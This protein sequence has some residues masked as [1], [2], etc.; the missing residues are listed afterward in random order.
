MC[1]CVQAIVFGKGPSCAFLGPRHPPRHRPP[2]A[3]SALQ[4]LWPP[5]SRR[6]DRCFVVAPPP[7][8]VSMSLCSA[9]V[10]GSAAARKSR[11][12][13][14]TTESA[15][16]STMDT[17][18]QEA[19]DELVELL[20][21]DPR[22]IFPTLRWAQSS[23]VAA[24]AEA[25]PAD[26]EDEG[27][28]HDTYR[29]LYRV[30][31]DFL[32]QFLPSLPEMALRLT[33]EALARL[34]KSEDGAVRNLFF[35]ACNVSTDTVWPPFCHKKRI[36]REVFTNVVVDRGNRLSGIV[37]KEV[38]EKLFV[39]WTKCGV[40][41]FGPAGGKKEWVEHVPTKTRAQLAECGFEGEFDVQNNWHE[42]KVELRVRRQVTR[43]TEFFEEDFVNSL[44]ASHVKTRAYL[45]EKA[46]NARAKLD[47]G[48]GGEEE[49][50]SNSGSGSNLKPSPAKPAPPRQPS[51]KAKQTPRRA[52]KK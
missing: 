26:D 50:T 38:G 52:G 25:P 14:R 51:A 41:V 34:E 22:K 23:A 37:T 18:E 39:D 21:Q 13:G 40:Y 24:R 2:C 36:F 46:N 49:P 5:A 15:I 3:C 8:L 1:V 31:K 47:D 17:M 44:K 19:L 43:I 9:S 42:L 27:D 35:W 4:T 30:P 11:K 10:A 33:S 45:Q 7:P 16:N 12:R 32:R 29:K 20:K 6:P 48:E 28:F